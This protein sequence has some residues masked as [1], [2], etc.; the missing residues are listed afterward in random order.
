[1]QSTGPGPRLSVTT[2]PGSPTACHSA[3]S[4]EDA[5]PLVSRPVVTAPAARASAG[6]LAGVAVIG[7]RA[8]G[9]LAPENTL[10]AIRLAVRDGADHIENDIMRTKD[11][12]LVITHDLDLT[13]TTDVEQVFP[14]RTSHHVADFTLVEIK[15]LDAGSWF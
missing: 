8:S 4:S 2:A 14:D 10:A 9:A 1:M 6:S 15:Q 12:A 5:D 3:H 13:R 11:G 7:H